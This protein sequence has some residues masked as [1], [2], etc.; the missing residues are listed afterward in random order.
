MKIPADF[1][2]TGLTEHCRLL[3]SNLRAQ[4]HDIADKFPSREAAIANLLEVAAK[5][6]YLHHC[7]VPADASQAWMQNDFRNAC[8]RLIEHLQ[9]IAGKAPERLQECMRATD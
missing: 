1:R 6:E 2:E 9:A 7:N 5:L 3:D 8:A 4:I